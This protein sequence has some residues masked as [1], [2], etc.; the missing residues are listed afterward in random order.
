[1][2]DMQF[3]NKKIKVVFFNSESFN[4][5]VEAGFLLALELK[6]YK[7]KDTV[8]LGIPRGGVVVAKALAEELKANLDIVITR[9]IG[10]PDNPEFAIG[11]ISE[12]GSLFINE[13]AGYELTSHKAFI[14]NEK[15]KQLAV[16]KERSN[17]FRKVKPK[18]NLKEKIV[19]VT[20][21]GLA[22]GATM[23]A[24]LWSI[25]KELPKK[26]IVAVPV[27]SEDSLARIEND[28]DEIVCLRLPQ[29]FAAVGQFYRNFDQVSDEEVLEAL[30]KF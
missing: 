7:G 24:T 11:A 9:K 22:T 20:D 30:K 4:D 6:K 26:I 21:D 12:D 23:Q 27:A 13:A 10:A 5:R 28:A 3:M 1:M 8:I 2:A 16:I 29:F 25:R 14:E 19:I 18:I 17:I 15:K